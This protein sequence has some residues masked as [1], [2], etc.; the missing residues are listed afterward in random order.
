MKQCT[1]SVMQEYIHTY[2]RIYVTSYYSW[3]PPP[4]KPVL[5]YNFHHSGTAKTVSDK[6]NKEPRGKGWRKRD[7]SADIQCASSQQHASY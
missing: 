3:T 4:H 7:D 2:L 6:S 1:S 5:R